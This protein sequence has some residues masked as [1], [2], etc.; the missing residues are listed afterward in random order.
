LLCRGA[1]LR[2]D[3]VVLR[4][5][6][7]AA[8]D[9]RKGCQRGEKMRALADSDSELLFHVWMGERIKVSVRIRI[10]QFATN[11]APEAL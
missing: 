3:G 5:R 6:G 4:P 9:H 2:R 1:L 10:S 8:A 11:S 7:G